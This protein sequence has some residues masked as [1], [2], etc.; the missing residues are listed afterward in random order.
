[1]DVNAINK[2]YFCNTGDGMAATE[3]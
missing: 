1:M 3:K 2:R